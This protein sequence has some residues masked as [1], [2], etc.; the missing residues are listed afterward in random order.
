MP[1]VLFFLGT[2][3]PGAGLVYALL[4]PR[5]V[6]Y[7]AR[8]GAPIGQILGVVATVLLLTALLYLPAKRTETVSAPNRRLVLAHVLV[9]AVALGLALAHSQLVVNQPPILVLLALL[10]LYGTGL[11]GRLLASRRM[12]PTFGRGGQPFRPAPALPDSFRRLIERKRELLARIE[13]AAAEATFTLLLSHWTRRPVLAV[14]YYG[15]SLEERRQMRALEAAGYQS[16][17]GAV[18]RWWRVGHLVLAWL[19]ILGLLTHVVTTLFFAE[20]AARGR[21]IYW[22]HLRK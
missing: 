9:G 6:P 8:P 10:G 1:R 14:R 16:Q 12:G 15:L 19:V 7:D 4:A 20:F 21:E 13:P 3:V 17:M 2:A 22:W 11:Y 18:E 5:I